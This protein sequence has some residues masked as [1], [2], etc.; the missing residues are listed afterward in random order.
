MAI[1]VD[2]Q[3]LAKMAARRKNEGLVAKYDNTKATAVSTRRAFFSDLFL[4]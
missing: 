2:R 4:Q 1:K 3:R